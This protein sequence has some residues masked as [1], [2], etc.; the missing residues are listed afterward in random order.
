MR[1]FILSPLT[2]LFLL[3]AVIFIAVLVGPDERQPATYVTLIIFLGFIGV[4]Q[5]ILNIFKPRLRSIWL[6]EGA[7]VII[8]IG[9]F[10]WLFRGIQ[11]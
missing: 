7:I 8:L 10:V 11:C 9:V 2:I 6:V 1:K 3:L 5:T 4:D